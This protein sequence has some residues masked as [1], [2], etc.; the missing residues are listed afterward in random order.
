MSRRDPR[1]ARFGRPHRYTAKG[2]PRGFVRPYLAERWDDPRRDRR[3]R[4][5]NRAVFV[6]ILANVTAFTRALAAMS[7]SVKL[8]AERL[9]AFG[10]AAN[11]V[12]EVRRLF[13]QVGIAPVDQEPA[14]AE[15]LRL[16]RETGATLLE[17]AEQVARAHARKL[18]TV[19]DSGNTPG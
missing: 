14:F 10:R 6:R 8:A 2:R 13:W 9:A 16:Q 19:V 7:V 4:R 5:R 18:R 15:A 11:E 17:A 12:E 3:L 1:A